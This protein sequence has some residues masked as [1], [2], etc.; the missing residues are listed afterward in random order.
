MR[1]CVERGH[2]SGMCL[3]AIHN[4]PRTRRLT[5]ATRRIALSPPCSYNI[6]THNAQRFPQGTFVR[7]EGD[8]EMFGDL[9]PGQMPYRIIVPKRSEAT[10]VL[11][12]VPTSASHL[13][14]G[15][16]RLEPQFMILGQSAGVAA[17]QAI[18]AGVAVQDVDVPTLQA[19][20]RAL[21]QLID[22]P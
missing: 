1:V 22:M 10:N 5:H 11:A 9:G 12:P 21:G 6:D 2:R 8:V 15:T 18:K 17:A 19:R 20:L 7:N 3:Q 14:Y 4:H 13:G 16:I